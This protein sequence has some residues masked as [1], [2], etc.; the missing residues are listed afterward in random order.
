MFAG[1]IHAANN[2]GVKIWAVGNE[3]SISISG[4]SNVNNFNFALKQY[5]GKDTIVAVQKGQDIVF[6]KGAVRLNV[7]DFKNPNPILTKD[8][9]KTVRAKE[10]PEI[11]MNFIVLNGVPEGG[12][13]QRM[14]AQ[15]E[16]K[17]AGKSKII[18]VMLNACRNGDNIAIRGFE[19]VYFSDFGLT[20]PTNVLGFINVK[21]DL[22]VNFQ[23]SLKVVN[24]G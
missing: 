4:S 15:I 24:E 2:E 20:P 10:F 7:A 14:K 18:P 22:T 1:I 5:N 21:N 23:L 12:Q 8:F 9:K 17:L 6:K 3:S 13:N 19:T 11:I 16:I